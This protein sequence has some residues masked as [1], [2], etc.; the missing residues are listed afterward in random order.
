MSHA[1][2]L[3]RPSGPGPLWRLC[4]ARKAP[5]AA[6]GGR[7]HAGRREFP[8]RL[9][10]G[11]GGH[12]HTDTHAAARVHT[13]HEE[14]ES[15]L[16]SDCAAVDAPWPSLSC[17]SPRVLVPAESTP[18]TAAKQPEKVAATRQEIFQGE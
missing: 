18:V 17:G 5:A 9:C 4:L 7:G 10:P 11:R 6:Q 16:E 1:C 3:Q 14:V 8:T 13:P 2:V 15:T 12:L